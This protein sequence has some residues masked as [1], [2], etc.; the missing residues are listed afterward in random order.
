MRE[1]PR[2]GGIIEDETGWWEIVGVDLVDG[3]ELS[4]RDG[5]TRWSSL[6]NL[7]PVTYQ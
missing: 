2:I 5:E 7:G 1:L 6:A 3:I 4:G